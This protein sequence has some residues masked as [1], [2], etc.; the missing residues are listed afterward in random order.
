MVDSGVDNYGYGGLNQHITFPNYIGTR[1]PIWNEL[2]LIKHVCSI[3][4]HF[5]AHILVFPYREIY[6]SCSISTPTNKAKI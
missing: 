6:T 2:S 1:T 3:Q 4:E 5:P